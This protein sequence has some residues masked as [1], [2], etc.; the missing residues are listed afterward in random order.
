MSVL[1]RLRT[2]PQVCSNP[3]TPLHWNNTLYTYAKEHAIDMAVNNRLSHQGSGTQTD[4]TAQRLGLKRGS[5]FY[6]RVNQAKDSRKIL[7]GEL[8]LSV[9]AHSMKLPRDVL[10][11]WISNPKDCKVIMDSRFTDVALSK[12]INDKTNKAYWVL[13]LAG[14]K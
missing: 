10:Y 6:E 3:T 8:V 14:A 11:Y 12:V 5:Y 4:K 9:N 7:S 2:Q 13:L 1:N